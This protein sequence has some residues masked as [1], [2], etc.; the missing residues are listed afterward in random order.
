VADNF[1]QDPLRDENQMFENFGS[2]NPMSLVFGRDSRTRLWSSSGRTSLN[3]SMS[4]E[5]GDSLQGKR[6][7]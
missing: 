4:P 7:S 2:K 3:A 5:N 6:I 1:A